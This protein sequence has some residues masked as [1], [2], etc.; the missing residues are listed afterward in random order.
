MRTAP[1]G[2]WETE[3]SA[4]SAQQRASGLNAESIEQSLRGS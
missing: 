1:A 4:A 3:K 2:S